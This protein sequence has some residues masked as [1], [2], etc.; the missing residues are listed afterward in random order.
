MQPVSSLPQNIKWNQE[1]QEVTQTF[2]LVECR[3][4]YYHIPGSDVL[5]DA[6]MSWL[7]NTFIQLSPRFKRDQDQGHSQWWTAC[8][9]FIPAQHGVRRRA[10]RSQWSRSIYAHPFLFVF[11]PLNAL[12]AVNNFTL[13]YFSISRQKL[14]KLVLKFVAVVLCVLFYIMLFKNH[15]AL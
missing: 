1:C 12:L 7:T 5:C 9:T 11:L 2:L 6:Q 4:V 3:L 14:P 10:E 13:T 15:R 8:L